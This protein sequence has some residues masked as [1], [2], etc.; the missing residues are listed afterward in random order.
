MHLLYEMMFRNQLFKNHYISP[1]RYRGSPGLK[2]SEL[3]FVSEELLICKLHVN[4]PLKIFSVNMK[5]CYFLEFIVSESYCK[6][7]PVLAYKQTATCLTF[8]S[9][10]PCWLSPE[11]LR[12]ASAQKLKLQLGR[13]FII[14]SSLSTTTTTLLLVSLPEVKFWGWQWLIE[15]KILRFIQWELDPQVWGFHMS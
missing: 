8:M 5:N 10:G 6:T 7:S 15:A 13:G 9:P 1:E 3:W 14:F 4:I 12:I 2:W 11:N